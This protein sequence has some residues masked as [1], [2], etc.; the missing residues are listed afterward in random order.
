[1]PKVNLADGSVMKVGEPVSVIA[2]IIV[3]MIVP[4]TNKSRSWVEFLHPMR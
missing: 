1:M 3:A 2:T 4:E